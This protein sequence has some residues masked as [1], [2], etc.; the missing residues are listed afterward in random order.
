MNP[1]RKVVAERTISAISGEGEVILHVG[2]N[3]SRLRLGT[4]MWTIGD[5]HLSIAK[6]SLG[7]VR[8]RSFK[9]EG[10]LLVSRAWP[11]RESAL[12][13]E[14]PTDKKGGVIVERLIGL[15]PVAGME[16]ESIEHWRSLESLTGLLASSLGAKGRGA[17]AI[18]FGRGQ[19]RVL[20]IEGEEGASVFARPVFRE[21]PR[22]VAT[23]SEEGV[24][25]LYRGKKGPCQYELDRGLQAVAIGD[26][27]RFCHSDGKE[28]CALFLPWVGRAEREEL[29]RRLQDFGPGCRK[30]CEDAITR[31]EGA[32]VVRAEP[33]GDEAPHQRLHTQ[34]IRG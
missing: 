27:I 6:T 3:L 29:T 33:G 21:R 7:R 25:R 30:I 10:R 28:V 5:T 26:Q 31:N 8:T 23:L 13:L 4:R 15:P 11:T 18:E 12:W 9:I 16:E 14:G 32:S 24:L 17:K 20:L 22:L 1:Y 2:P 19:H 34:A